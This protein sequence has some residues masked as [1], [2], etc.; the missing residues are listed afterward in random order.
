MLYDW[1][2]QGEKKNI[3]YICHNPAWG[4]EGKLPYYASTS[5]YFTALPVVLKKTFTITFFLY[6]LSHLEC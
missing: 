2:E 3:L 6:K 5:K 1:I 4:N